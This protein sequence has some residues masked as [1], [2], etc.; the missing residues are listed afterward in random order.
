MLSFTLYYSHCIEAL[1][2][3]MFNRV[4]T[5]IGD[6]MEKL[7]MD[8][9]IMDNRLLRS[10]LTELVGEDQIST[11]QLISELLSLDLHSRPASQHESP[12]NTFTA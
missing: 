8:V 6:H 3:E 1:G 2:M 11:C 10:Q 7:S 9:P 4:Y 12:H 5:L